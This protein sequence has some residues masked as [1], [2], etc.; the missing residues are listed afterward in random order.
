MQMP[1]L[2]SSFIVSYFL[3]VKEIPQ[4]SSSRAGGCMLFFQELLHCSSVSDETNLHLP[5]SNE[6]EARC[7]PY[8]LRR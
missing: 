6:A 4:K 3:I 7:S 8:I 2:W 1:T 5:A